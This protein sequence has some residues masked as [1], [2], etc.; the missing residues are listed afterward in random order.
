MKNALLLIVDVQN[1]FVSEVT[2]SVVPKL[3]DLLSKKKFENV[4][5]TKY[6]NFN[7]S[8]FEKYLNWFRLK[9]DEEQSLVSEL[10]PL[11]TVV[12]EKTVYTAIND[13]MKE[14]LKNNCIDTVY[15]AGIDTDCCVLTSAVDLFQMGIRPI[16]LADY[17]ASNGGPESHNAALRV[18]HRLIGESQIVKGIC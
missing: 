10:M 1:G 8:P 13:D 6:C 2:A 11:A 3:V 15:I 18:L 17:C 5:F 4:A 9:T 7:S 16:V 14:Y 12:F